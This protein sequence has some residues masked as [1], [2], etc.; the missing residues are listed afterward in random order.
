MRSIVQI[1]TCALLPSLLLA[2]DFSG[3]FE[4]PE[5]AISLP[6]PTEVRDYPA[7][8][9]R[10]YPSTAILGANVP[11]GDY[12]RAG[13]LWMLAMLCG[14][15]KDADDN[16]FTI[17][18]LSHHAPQRPE[19]AVTWETFTSQSLAEANRIAPK[20]RSSAILA[21]VSFLQHLN[22]KKITAKKPVEIASN[23]AI[24]ADA[25]Q[26]PTDDENLLL[27]LVRPAQRHRESKPHS[28]LLFV[29]ELNPDKRNL[30]RDW[31]RDFQRKVLEQ[32]ERIDYYDRHPLVATDDPVRS[33]ALKSIRYNK[34][35]QAVET[36]DFVLLTNLHSALGNNLIQTYQQTRPLM[37]KAFMALVP[38]FRSAEQ[39][40]DF[41]R[42]IASKEDYIRYLGEDLAWTAGVWLPIRRELILSLRENSKDTL[43][44]VCHESFH[45]YLSSAL[46]YV[47]TSAWFNE[48]H[49]VLFQHAKFSNDS[50][51]YTITEKERETIDACGRDLPEKVATVL[52]AS[53][54]DFYQIEPT[55]NYA[56]AHTIVYYL[57]CVAPYERRSNF[58]H[59]IENYLAELQVSRNANQA[60][61]KA[62]PSEKAFTD[63]FVRW[64]KKFRTKR[65]GSFHDADHENY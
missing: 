50:V 38:P 15:W 53:Y 37:Q 55:L 61:L 52:N 16:F 46:E 57:Q 3:R 25:F 39:P 9:P 24:L 59:T 18:K 48:G 21:A 28:W 60:M 14:Q 6:T 1:L 7:R 5:C 45:Q 40:T 54:Q 2:I 32:I 29:L 41:V 8:M 19:S 26:L 64:W 47:T 22:G 36:D 12:Y 44:T 11:T 49:A 31:Q 17:A 35:W 62:F 30:T 56:L 13:E 33:L 42:L 63:E 51:E 23:R 10:A 20:D 58:K 34:Q 27:H 43:S 4:M 65:D